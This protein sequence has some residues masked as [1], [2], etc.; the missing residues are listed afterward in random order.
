[1]SLCIS[2]EDD[3]AERV[4]SSSEDENAKDFTLDGLDTRELYNGG[5]EKDGGGDDVGTSS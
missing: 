4:L 2:D 5:V 3:D 1:L